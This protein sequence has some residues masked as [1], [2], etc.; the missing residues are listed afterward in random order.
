MA[1]GIDS[2]FTTEGTTNVNFFNGRILTAEDL[3]S[4]AEA[5][6]EHRRRLGRA[7]GPGLASGLRATT[8]GGMMVRVTEGV[9]VNGLGDVIR[10]PV[11][12]DV[13]VGQ[14]PS[15]PDSPP[16]TLFAECP[17]A[18]S[19]DLDTTVV[20]GAFYLLTIRPASENVGQAPGADP[21]GLGTVCG[22][23]WTRDGVRFRRVGLDLGRLFAHPEVS[24]PEGVFSLTDPVSRSRL[25]SELAH[26]F[27]GTPW[28]IAQGREPDAPVQLEQAWVDANLDR[29]EV[30]IA[31]M[32]IRGSQIV[33]V[34]EWA[35]RRPPTHRE[36]EPSHGWELLLDGRRRSVG[37]GAVLQFHAQ[38][39][40]RIDESESVEAI[41]DFGYLPAAGILPRVTGL[42]GPAPSI[43]QTS[44]PF[45]EGLPHR[46]GDL[47]VGA[48]EVE[49]ILRSAAPATPISLSAPRGPINVFHVVDSE[50]SEQPYAVFVYQEH[51]SGMRATIVDLAAT[52]DDLVRRLESLEAEDTAEA[53]V[54]VIGPRD[55]ATVREGGRTTLNF[56]VRVGSAGTY[57]IDDP[58]VTFKDPRTSILATASVVGNRSF[59]TDAATSREVTV[60][61]QWRKTRPTFPT[62]R[63]ERRAEEGPFGGLVLGESLGEETFAMVESGG[64]LAE[65]SIE[66]SELL[67]E[68]EAGRFPTSR[69][70]ARVRLTVHKTDDPITSGFDDASVLFVS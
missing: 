53:S 19:D 48:H 67:G 7:I 16:T 54:R 59:S 52:I 32:G 39:A 42:F 30:P 25:R 43:D 20:G 61:V 68:R 10:L 62:R 8:A 5:G 12:V 58:T 51:W 35:V 6:A 17:G 31:L 41:S 29:C 28:L 18:R 13:N 66:S 50:R 14:A 45:L 46:I 55:V 65:G 57:R 40:Q 4:F 47:F 70:L 37:V 9:A 1:L 24:L 44:L 21:S 2:V 11:D 49:P 36:P 33:L 27:L 69:A 64:F 22:P 26:L 3:R 38:L 23:G 60:D 56:F 34:D 63:E 15:T